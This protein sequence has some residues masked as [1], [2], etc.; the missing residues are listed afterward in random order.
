MQVRPENDSVY[1]RLFRHMVKN[2]SFKSL[3]LTAMEKH[4]E[5]KITFKKMYGP[6]HQ[7]LRIYFI[8][9]VIQAH[10]GDFVGSI[11]G[12]HNKANIARE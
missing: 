5:S 8:L 11:L 10:L 12:H 4:V 2:H 1:T 7:C 9:M 6:F 3:L